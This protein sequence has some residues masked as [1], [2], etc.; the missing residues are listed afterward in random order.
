MIPEREGS[1]PIIILTKLI[2]ICNQSDP[3]LTSLLK[4]KANIATVPS[5]QQSIAP[6]SSLSTAFHK[7][8]RDTSW[9]CSLSPHRYSSENE[10]REKWLTA[11]QEPYA[12]I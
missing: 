11:W 8:L 3:S 5:S 4:N 9:K 12:T 1:E 6:T 2:S 10:I 7:V